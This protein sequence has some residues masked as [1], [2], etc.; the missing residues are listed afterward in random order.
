MTN[1]SYPPPPSDPQPY[2]QYPA[3]PAP[4]EY[5]TPPAYGAPPQAYQPYGY[6]PPRQYEGLAIASLV[7]SCAAVFG[8]CSWGIGGVLGIVGA[9]LGH[10]ARSRLKENGR[11]GAG[12]ALA[13]IIVGWVLAALS[14]VLAG[15]LVLLFV[16]ASHASVGT[17]T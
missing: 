5:G 17:P 11:Q 16:H 1:P 9:I 8:F 12:L 3:Y 10:V 4:P 14:A 2:Q 7:V 6:P 13:G 15:V